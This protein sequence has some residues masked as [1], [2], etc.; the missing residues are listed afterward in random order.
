M[1]RLAILPLALLAN[2]CTSQA[3]IEAMAEN[4]EADIRELLEQHGVDTERSAME[5]PRVRQRIVAHAVRQFK[6]LTKA[7]GCTIEGA[8]VAEW[9][10]RS[11]KYR[12]MAISLDAKPMA[13]ITGVITYDDNNSGEIFGTESHSSGDIESVTIEGLWMDRH[14]EADVFIGHT[15]MLNKD[16]LTLFATR[17]QRGLNGHFIGVLADCK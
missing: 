4:T 1:N 3:D 7:E 10:D 16:E 12:G 2:A 6:D 13:A 5:D 14:I 17:K 9:R 11:F 15:N 8:A